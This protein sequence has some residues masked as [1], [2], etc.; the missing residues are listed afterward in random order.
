MGD[1]F[2]KL[3]FFFTDRKTHIMHSDAN[4]GFKRLNYSILS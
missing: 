3:D 2:A 4:S 1:Q